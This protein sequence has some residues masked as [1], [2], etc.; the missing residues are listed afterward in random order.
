MVATY[1]FLVLTIIRFT[2]D[3]YHK[4]KNNFQPFLEIY[5]VAREIN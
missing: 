3:I 2:F 1:V 5:E 4:Y